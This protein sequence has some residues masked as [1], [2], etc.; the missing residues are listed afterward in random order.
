MS[1]VSQRASFTNLVRISLFRSFGRLLHIFCCYAA[2][3][4]RIASNVASGA[5]QRPIL[6]ASG[7]FIDLLYTLAKASL[8][9][10][11]S[12]VLFDENK[13]LSGHITIYRT[14]VYRKIPF[15]LSAPIELRSIKAHFYAFV[16]QQMIKDTIAAT[17]KWWLIK[18]GAIAEIGSII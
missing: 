1:P 6:L 14:E 8:V 5:F 3:K 7:A 4:W 9:C 11:P 15:H 10:A 17:L 18:P 16:R 13:G 12:L 2:F